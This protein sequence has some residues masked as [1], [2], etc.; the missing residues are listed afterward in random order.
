[1]K[2]NFFYLG[3]YKSNGT[4]RTIIQTT[5]NLY[6]LECYEK[7][8]WLFFLNI[9]FEISNFWLTTS[10]NICSCSKIGKNI[11]L[12]TVYNVSYICI[13]TKFYCLFLKEDKETVSGLISRMYYNLI[14]AYSKQESTG[15]TAFKNYYYE[16][17]QVDLS[18]TLWFGFIFN[19]LG[20][21]NFIRIM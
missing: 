4:Y 10:A 11:F 3:Y 12:W 2:Y 16:F 15:D 1:M 7:V 14:S 20:F 19:S 18:N 6:L 13:F 21:N 8:F 5:I 17:Y 9:S